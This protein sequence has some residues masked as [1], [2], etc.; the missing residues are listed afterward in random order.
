MF[1]SLFRDSLHIAL[2]RTNPSQP[3][4][5]LTEGGLNAVRLIFI[6]SDSLIGKQCQ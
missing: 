2:L 6:L 4:A 5:E 1:T 3:D